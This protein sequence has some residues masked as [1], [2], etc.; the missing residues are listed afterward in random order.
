MS[1]ILPTSA[2]PPI[3]QALVPAAVRKAGPAAVKTYD[4]ALSFEGVLDQQLAQS[5]TD[6][7]QGSDA[8]DDSS[9][10]DG[11]DDSSSTDP[12]TSLTMQML[13]QA[14]SQG[15]I[16]S[17]GIGLANQLYQA[18]GGPT[19]TSAPTTDTTSDPTTTTS[20]QAGSQS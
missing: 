12:A 1:S 20:T 17:G 13:P 18:L 19:G 3:D 11:S 8:S 10:D 9:S 14:L 16:S 7:L 4:T 2:L 5:L 6:T 15:L